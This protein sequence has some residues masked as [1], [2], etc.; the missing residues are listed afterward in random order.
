MGT[1]ILFPLSPKLLVTILGDAG[2]WGAGSQLDY[3][4]FGA[5]GYRL[6]E[7]FSLGAGYRY[8]FVNYRPGNSGI[9]ESALSGALI[10]VNYHFK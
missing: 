8:L 10:G 1:R 4:I 9:Y 2:G 5:I 3:Q 7:K 6:S